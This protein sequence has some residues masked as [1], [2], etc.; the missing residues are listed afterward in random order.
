MLTQATMNHHIYRRLQASALA[1]VGERFY[2]KPLLKSTVRILFTTGAFDDR[3]AFVHG[4]WLARARGAAR[5]VLD[6]FEEF[7]APRVTDTVLD[8]SSR[9]RTITALPR[10][11]SRLFWRRE[12]GGGR[13]FF[14]YVNKAVTDY[15]VSRH[16]KPAGDPQ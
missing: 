3:F 9:S 7:P 11:E 14:Q 13:K 5:D 4:D 2:V 8:Y 12:E 16:H 6:A 1:F 15:L 10:L